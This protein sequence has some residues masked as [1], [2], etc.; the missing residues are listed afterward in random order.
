VIL[1]FKLL[2]AWAVVVAILG[3]FWLMFLRWR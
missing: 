1:V 3:L 2:I